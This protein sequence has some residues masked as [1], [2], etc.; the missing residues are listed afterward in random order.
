[1]NPPSGLKEWGKAL[2]DQVTETN[3]FDPAG[4][5]ILAEACRTADII[6]T[7][8]GRLRSNST[9]WIRL[10]DEAEFAVDGYGKPYAKIRIVVDSALVEIRQ[11]RMALKQL[12][13]SLKLGHTEADT[14]EDS[15]V[16]RLM[17]EFN[18]PD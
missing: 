4:Y 6:E 12:L 10:A 13:A 2:W 5:Y 7:L 17:S 1:M 15:E 3:S 16:E 11:Q 9:E 8:S 14:G 18:L